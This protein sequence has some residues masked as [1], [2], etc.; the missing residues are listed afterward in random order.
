MD[1]SMYSKELLE[2]FARNTVNL[3]E[4]GQLKSYNEI[5]DV[6]EP[7]VPALDDVFVHHIGLGK[8]IDDWLEYLADGNTA[9]AIH[10][11]RIVVEDL[12]KYFE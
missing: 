8:A 12:D 2:K 7:L 1:N 9:M 5:R 4:A 10:Q 6:L 11:R 3:I